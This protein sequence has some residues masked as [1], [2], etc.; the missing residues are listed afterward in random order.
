MVDGCHCTCCESYLKQPN[1][2]IAV[3]HIF[4]FLCLC[5]AYCKK[6]KKKNTFRGRKNNINL[7]IQNGNRRAKWRRSAPAAHGVGRGGR[8]VQS[9]GSGAGSATPGPLGGRGS[10][11]AGAPCAW[12]RAAA[13]CLVAHPW[14]GKGWL[15]A[16]LPSSSLCTNVFEASF[17]PEWLV[18]LFLNILLLLPLKT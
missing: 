8:R 3:I 1:I 16:Q 12:S 11:R 10:E 13:R 5:S 7:Y 2:F 6:K 17:S 18:L 9:G 15:Q 4:I 14:I